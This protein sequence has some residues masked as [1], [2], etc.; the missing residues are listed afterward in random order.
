MLMYDRVSI[1]AVAALY[2]S[3]NTPRDG[4]SSWATRKK[5]KKR[6]VRLLSKVGSAEGKQENDGWG[7]NISVLS[8]ERAVELRDKCAARAYDRSFIQLIERVTRSNS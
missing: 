7:I 5:E 8:R 1:R 4:S 2:R 3:A 6:P